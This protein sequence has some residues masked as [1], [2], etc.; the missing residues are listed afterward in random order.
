MSYIEQSLGANET[1]H[2][3]ARFPTARYAAAW[4]TLLFGLVA[5]I[6]CLLYGAPAIAAL[7]LI[8]AATGFCA[9][10][11]EPWTTEIAVTNLRLIY[12]RGLFQ[13]RTNDLQLRAIEE[14]Q[15]HQNF[16]GRLLNFGNVEFH[17]TGV[18][19]IRPPALNNPIAFQR[20]V[21]EAIG[22][23]HDAA[24]LPDQLSV[25]TSKAS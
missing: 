21:Q 15:L 9:I 12:K 5:G 6:S 10:L 22:A 1:V 24:K 25:P 19:D 16:L 11:Y 7:I 3:A 13:R 14:V 17:G 8:C 2:Y 18:D 23:N 4:L 20:A